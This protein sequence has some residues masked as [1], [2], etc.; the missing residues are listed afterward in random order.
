MVSASPASAATC[1]TTWISTGFDNWSSPSAWDHGVPT[2]SSNACI[3]DLGGETVQ[4]STPNPTAASLTIGENVVLRVEG[5]GDDGDAKLTIT[6]GGI[7]S[8][9]HIQLTSSTGAFAAAISVDGPGVLFN[10]GSI[11][12][13]PGTGGARSIAGT[14]QSGG[15]LTATADASLTGTLINL[16]SGTVQVGDSTHTS[17]KLSATSLSNYDPVGHSLGGRGGFQLFGTLSVPNLDVRTLAAQLLLRSASAHLQDAV[18]ANA[19]RH[20]TSI[21]SEG[22]LLL[23]AGTLDIGAPHVSGYIRVD[24]ATLHTSGPLTIAL[25]GLVHL[26]NPAAKVQLQTGAV[27]VGLGGTLSGY[28]QIAGSLQ[29]AGFMEVQGPVG[30]KLSVTGTFTQLPTGDLAMDVTST[31]ANTTTLAVGGKAMLAGALD[32]L[33][34]PG[35]TGNGST[36]AAVTAAHRSGTFR[37]AF[38]VLA[39]DQR[40]LTSYT[41]TRVNLTSTLTRED[42]DI[43]IS[44]EHW[45]PGEGS[46]FARWVRSSNE[47]GDTM[48]FS[49]SG[50]NLTWFVRTGPDQGRAQITVDGAHPRIVDLYSASASEPVPV[51]IT[52]PTTGNHVLRIKVTGTKNPLSTGTT[53]TVR[54]F[55]T[56]SNGSY[57]LAAPQV[58][59]GGWTRTAD[60]AATA[61]SLRSA[62]EG[63][64]FVQATFTGVRLD[65]I[66]QTCPSCGRAAVFIDSTMKVV[67]LYSAAKHSQVVKSFPVTGLGTHTITIVVLGSKN[68]A[69]AG[70]KV[71]VDALRPVLAAG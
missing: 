64:R 31:L 22:A 34:D 27:K 58:G 9:G 47:P 56:P 15:T 54:G 52:A 12:V 35:A 49:F 59:I 65:W 7:D 40:V 68:R 44:Y 38:V 6:S 13:L 2:A 55:Q 26:Q 46:D 14:I 53:V 42:D 61:G 28:G 69:S 4:V 30:Q 10:G 17:V 50:K 21:P 20:L 33:P 43:R 41:G 48:S 16:D 23:D 63:G 36:I 62:T 66:T 71:V 29:N 37:S 18:G 25:G 70:T 32:L 19:L 8:A 1:D 51:A 45:Q 11:E 57:D 24:A 39:D 3:P 60:A 67:D 5:N